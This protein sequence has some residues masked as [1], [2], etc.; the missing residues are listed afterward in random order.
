LGF[1]EH[2]EKKRSAESGRHS[3][4][5]KRFAL[6][7]ARGTMDCGD[8]LRELKSDAVQ[9]GYGGRESEAGGK[10]GRDGLRIRRVKNS[11]APRIAVLAGELDI[12]PR[13]PRCAK[14]LRGI[15]PASQHA[16]LVAETAE[17]GVYRLAAREQGAAS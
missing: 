3:R 7:F 10:S 11:D 14:R 5:E 12:R 4:S 9:A 2:R 8:A 1:A 17:D 15:G 13:Q 6:K 16:V